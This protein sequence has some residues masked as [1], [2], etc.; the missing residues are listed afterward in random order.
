[1][2]FPAQTNTLFIFIFL[3]SSFFEDYEWF[4]KPNSNQILGSEGTYYFT[5]LS[6]SSI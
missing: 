2:P 6:N 4:L 5:I 1:M 3:S